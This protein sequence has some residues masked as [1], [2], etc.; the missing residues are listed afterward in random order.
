MLSPLGNDRRRDDPWHRGSNS[1]ID[2]LRKVPLLAGLKRSDLELVARLADEV[3]LPAG[4]VIFREGDA[5]HEFFMVISGEVEVSRR[6]KVIAIDRE[7]AFF[8][9]MALMIHKPRNATLTCLT[10]CRLLVLATREFNSLLA[11]SPEIQNALLMELAERFAGM[12]L[13][14]H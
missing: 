5:G 6:G 1:K 3:D 12:E 7:G 10:D 9:E 2:L 11:Q 13:E 4:R 8:G 14:A